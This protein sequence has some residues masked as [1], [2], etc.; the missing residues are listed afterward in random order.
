M[1]VIVEFV[2]SSYIADRGASP[3]I[4]VSTKYYSLLF[5]F[6][7]TSYSYYMFATTAG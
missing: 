5:K 3:L 1:L 2:Y 4:N 7:A 6:V